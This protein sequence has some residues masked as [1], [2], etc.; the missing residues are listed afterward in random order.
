MWR[1]N[2]AL[3]TTSTFDL[4]KANYSAAEF[5]AVISFCLDE[6]SKTGS[7]STWV[8]SNHDVVRHATRYG[9][10]AGLGYDEWL[11]TDGTL[12]LVDAEEGLR[13]ARA[14]TLLMF[15][16][17]GSSYLYQGEELG[18]HEVADIPHEALQDPIWLRTA[19]TKKGR[20]GCRVPLPWED[21]GRSYGFGAGHAH[22]PQPAGFSR[23]AVA[24]QR[25]RTDST[26]ELYRSAL[27]LRRQLQASEMLT[28]VETGRDD[29]LHFVRPG[30]WHCVSNFGLDDVALSEG[31][32]QVASGPIVAGMLPG[33][34][35]VWF[36]E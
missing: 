32:I 22:R 12:P 36:T 5:H 31:A 30:G 8:L 34:T 19:N 9:L 35:T 13:R 15:A 25:G 23:A 14:A 33:E 20:D 28:W 17:P 11:M 16:L 6:A 27:R 18:L 7:S 21:D 2:W 3:S 10:P 1:P 4:L 29:V 26:L 24:A